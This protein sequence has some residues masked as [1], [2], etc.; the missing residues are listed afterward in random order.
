M[1]TV[2]VVGRLYIGIYLINTYEKMPISIFF[3]SFII[4][5]K[6]NQ[7]YVYYWPR[8]GLCFMISIYGDEISLLLKTCHR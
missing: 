2:T 7:L 4:C 1:W 3:S 6:E 8:V 5:A